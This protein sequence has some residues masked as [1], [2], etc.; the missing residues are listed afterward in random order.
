MSRRRLH[1]LL[2][3]VSLTAPV[4][5]ACSGGPETAILSHFF[6]AARLRDN[7][8]LGSFATANFDPRE[9][10]IVT[11]FT[12]TNIGPE[13]RRALALKALAKE[14]DE[15][16]AADADLTKRK[17]AYADANMD[18]V[19]GVI[20]AGRDAK[21]K[22]SDAEVQAA[23]FKF[24]DEGAAVGRRVGEARRKLAAEKDIVELSAVEPGQTLDVTKYDGDLV[25]KDLTITA[26]VKMPTGETITKTLVVT[27]AR[28]E[29]KGDR[30]IV[31]RWIIATI[32]EPGT[33]GATKAS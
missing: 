21:L 18:A 23:W 3:A 5:A 33:S 19:Q 10:G 9:Q 24:L 31:G 16:K 12:I 8:T 29:L 28:A 6:T 11:T 7:T 22:G 27:F 20:K 30:Q 4:L 25:K 17:D 1:V 13:Q 2:L 32:K 14:Y 15:A 26:P